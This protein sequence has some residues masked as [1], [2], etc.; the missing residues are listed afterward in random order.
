MNKKYP[1]RM[2][3]WEA[4][5]RCNANCRFCG[6]RCSSHA[7]VDEVDAEIVINAFRN[8]AQN[9]DASKIMVNVTGGEPLLRKDLIKIM[10][11][12][13]N[14]GF[15]W[16]LVTNGTL[17]SADNIIKLKNA[18]MSTIS[19]SIDGLSKTHNSLRGVANGFERI[20]N[21]ISEL[22][23]QD[24][25][26]TIM[27]TTVVTSENIHELDELKEFLKTQPIDV[28]RIVPVDKIGRASDDCDILLANNQ[29]IETFKFIKSVREEE[30][31]FEVTTSCSHYLGRFEFRLRDF[32][33]SCQSGKNICSILSNGDIYVCPNVERVPELIQGNIKRDRISEIW[34]NG[35]SFFRSNS[36]CESG[37]CSKCRY[38]SDCHGDS[39]HTWDFENNIPKFCAHEQGLIDQNCSTNL[40]SAGYNEIISR[41]KQ[42]SGKLMSVSVK[43]QS[44]SKDRIIILPETSEKLL[45]FFE[46]DTDRE[47]EEKICALYGRLYKDPRKK[48]CYTVVVSDMFPI[49][50][51]K[52]SKTTIMVD[53]DILL[54]HS[55]VADDSDHEDILIGFAHSHPNALDISMSLGDY[56]FHRYLYSNDWRSALTIIFN[57]QKKH[58]AAYAGPAANHVELN[59]LIKPN[60][61]LSFS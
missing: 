7:P 51:L 25:V 20:I 34:E 60:I 31:P 46:C 22:T 43:A 59:I 56:E 28:W 58:F 32:P 52:T 3:M 21:G 50:G 18:G 47:T 11:S 53:Y 24:F 26:E 14:L 40:P 30:L 23:K 36:R 8:I 9:Y 4:T 17:L 19:I 5:S 45:R 2:L 41:I 16:G 35:F 54:S 49:N 27:I 57:P 6:S 15:K 37:K 48:D 12:V 55:E 39:L 42:S 13:R 38:I 1:L 29:I 44:L 61:L 33:F 10:E